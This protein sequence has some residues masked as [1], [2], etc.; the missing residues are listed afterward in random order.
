MLSQIFICLAVIFIDSTFSYGCS[1]NELP[2]IVDGHIGT[3]EAYEGARRNIICR[4]GYKY[5]GSYPYVSCLN[6]RWVNPGYQCVRGN[7]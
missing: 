6:G 2:R 7:F 5:T 3:G 1:I 4:T